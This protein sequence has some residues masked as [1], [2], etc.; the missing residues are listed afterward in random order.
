MRT[1]TIVGGSMLLFMLA[2]ASSVGTNA[3]AP[4]SQGAAAGIAGGRSRA[5][6]GPPAA[7]ADARR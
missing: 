3:Q 1:L 4:P 6:A 2:G 5:R 7:P